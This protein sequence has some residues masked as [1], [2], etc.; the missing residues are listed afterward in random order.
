MCACVCV[1]LGAPGDLFGPAVL[2]VLTHTVLAWLLAGSQAL[3][4]CACCQLRSQAHLS[5]ET[6]TGCL[7]A[8]CWLMQVGGSVR[9]CEGVGALIP[10]RH[11]QARDWLLRCVRWLGELAIVTPRNRIVRTVVT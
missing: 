6:D 9:S 8:P 3:T 2:C 1:R 11:R 10:C 5:A 7:I 4:E